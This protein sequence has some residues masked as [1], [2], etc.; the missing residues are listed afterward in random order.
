MREMKSL[1]SIVLYL[2]AVF[3]G[4]ADNGLYKP[5]T[6]T[7]DTYQSAA[8]SCIGVPVTPICALKT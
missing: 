8:E 1:F 7:V 2:L 3:P 5:L 4:Y 6:L